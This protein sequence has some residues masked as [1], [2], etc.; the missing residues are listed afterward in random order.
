MIK[1]W[2]AG[3]FL[4][5]LF[6]IFPVPAGENAEVKIAQEPEFSPLT[7][8]A[9]FSSDHQ[10]PQEAGGEDLRTIIVTGDVIPSRGVNIEARRR[11]FTYPW[12][13]MAEFT[14]SGDLTI[15][16][17]EAPL[18]KNCPVLSE[19]FTFCGDKRNLE[20]LVFGGVDM[21]SLENNHIGNFGLAGITETI[22]YL[23]EAGI[24][25]TRRDH[26]A[27]EEVRGL[28]FGMLGFNGIGEKINRQAMVEE[29]QKSRPQV[30]ILL[31]QYHWGKEY[32]RLPK[33]DGGIAPDDPKE[34][35]KLAIDAG[36]DL[37]IGNH[38]HWV[39]GI[40]F[41]KGKLITYAHGNFIFDQMWSE[42]TRIGVV[43]K[44]VFYKEK[45]VDV[46]YVPVKIFDY[47][48]PRFILGEEA[49]IELAKM[50]QASLELAG[51]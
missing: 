39:Q 8:E 25:W 23:E 17:L 49:E 35:G 27:I 22:E 36:A 5:G 15:I 28:K 9:I 3:G 13:Q 31:V 6:L 11:G 4:F 30:D 38:S 10:L 42:E 44:Y 32:E 37:V 51:K 40:E 29:I 19:G 46:S 16:D 1:F 50:R 21:A 47:S 20:G 7:I 26:L 18:L 12:A 43:G 34:I 41:Y 33:T 48:Q 14:S 2:F 24:S 45:L